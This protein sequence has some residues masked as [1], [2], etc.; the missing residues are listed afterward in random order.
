M[1]NYSKLFPES[2]AVDCASVVTI[3][4]GTKLSLVD[5]LCKVEKTVMRVSRNSF[6]ASLA[7][8]TFNPLTRETDAL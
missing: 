5:D 6:A 7:L 3:I 2:D 8:G 1:K 4:P